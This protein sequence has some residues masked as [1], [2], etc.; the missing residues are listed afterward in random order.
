VGTD[1]ERI[2]AETSHLL[3]DEAAYQRMALAA[4]PYGDG[5]AAQRIVTA[6]W[7]VGG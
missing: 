2:V 5:Q 1:P 4:N 6:L 3:E 7:K